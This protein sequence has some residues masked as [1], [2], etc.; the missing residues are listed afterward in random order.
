M[1]LVHCVLFEIIITMSA[2]VHLTNIGLSY[3]M[4][5]E[6]SVEHSAIVSC[7]ILTFSKFRFAFLFESGILNSK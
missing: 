7:T 5:I 6:M 4:K 3:M 2:S 1:A